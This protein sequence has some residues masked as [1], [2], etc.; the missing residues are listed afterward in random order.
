MTL[1]LAQYV[2]ILFIYFFRMLKTK[3]VS[4]FKEKL[5]Q[6]PVRSERKDKS[7]KRKDLFDV[8]ST[9]EFKSLVTRQGMHIRILL[10][11]DGHF[12]IL[13]LIISWFFYSS[14]NGRSAKSSR[15]FERTRR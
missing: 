11:L 8:V 4:K 2:R 13:F 7:R 1:D 5:Q 15:R 10:M 3:T 9:P 14:R 12:M 6:E